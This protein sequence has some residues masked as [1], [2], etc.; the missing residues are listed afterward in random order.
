V[1]FCFQCP[2]FPCDNTGFD[3][4]LFKRSVQ[5]NLRIQEIGIEKYYEEIRDKPRY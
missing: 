2:E 3:E 1:D 5:I 4:H